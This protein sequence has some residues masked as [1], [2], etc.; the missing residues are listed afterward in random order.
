MAGKG[1]ET[2]SGT[3]RPEVILPRG[4]RSNGVAP[5][6]QMA[7][8]L[9]NRLQTADVGDIQVIAGNS[10]AGTLYRVRVGPVADKTE[11]LAV[12]EQLQAGGYDSGQPLP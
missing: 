6:R 8:W 4:I 12:Q 1:E 2:G 11:L 9:R 10:S 7:E 5:L 3:A